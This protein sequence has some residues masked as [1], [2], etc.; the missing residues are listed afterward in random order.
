MTTAPADLDDALIAGRAGDLPLRDLIACTIANQLPVNAACRASWWS[1]GKAAEVAHEVISLIA[2]A[3]E[4]DADAIYH[5]SI[6]ALD[7]PESLGQAIADHLRTCSDPA[8]DDDAPT[9][10]EVMRSEIDDYIAKELDR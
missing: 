2:D 1:G 10:A 7:C 5:R 9:T 4:T 3:I 8:A 6:D